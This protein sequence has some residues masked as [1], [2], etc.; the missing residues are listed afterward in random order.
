MMIPKK[1]IKRAVAVIAAAFMFVAMM[2]VAE[3]LCRL[4][5]NLY[6]EL[7]EKESVKVYV[8]KIKD[9]SDNTGADTIALR[10]LLED[11][12]FAR[13]TITFDIVPK[14]EEADISVGC[15]ITEFLWTGEDPIDNI[16]GA[17]PILIGAVTK[18]NYAC[19]Q[20]VFTVTDVKKGKPMWEK[21]L[22]ATIR[23]NSMGP[24]ESVYMLNERMVKIF[25][26]DCLSR[27]DKP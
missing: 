10:K 5:K 25:F 23:D 17:G 2:F 18:S 7:S 12:L 13:M 24:A 1:R 22:K 15:D 16:A 4:K 21:K 19:M 26:R 6:D 11:E 20:A 3:G 8:E 9:S 14:R 27:P